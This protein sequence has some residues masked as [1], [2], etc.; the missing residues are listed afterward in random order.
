MQ[1]SEPFCL[2]V[3]G[4]PDLTPAIKKR[5]RQIGYVTAFLTVFTLGTT[6]I[7]ASWYSTQM[8]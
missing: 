7:F 4:E 1:E 2:D 6:E 3:A 8:D 5:N